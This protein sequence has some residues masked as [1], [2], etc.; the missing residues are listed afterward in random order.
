M[1][2]MSLGIDNDGH[3]LA[4]WKRGRDTLTLTF[5]VGDEIRWSVVQHEA[6]TV[7]SAA[8]RTR[9]ERLPL[10][11]KPYSPE[12]WFGNGDDISTA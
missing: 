12:I 2:A 9:L 5:L 3:I 8:G 11:L 10:V 7:E 4:G 1:K 6:D